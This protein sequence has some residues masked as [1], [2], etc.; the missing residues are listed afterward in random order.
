MVDAKTLGL[1]Q[2]V[3][4]GCLVGLVVL[5][6]FTCVRSKL[7]EVY[8]FRRYINR[9]QP[10]NNFNGARV[11]FPS[12][13]PESGLFGW[14]APTLGIEEEEIVS[15]IGLDAAMFLRFVKS[16]LLSFAIITIACCLV[17]W[18]AYGTASNKD[19]PKLA[20]GTNDPLF[21]EGLQILSLSNVPVQDARLWATLVMEYVVCAVFLFFLHKD[22]SQ[23]A[24]YRREYRTTENPAN[25][26]IVVYDIPSDMNTEDAVRERFELMVPDQVSEV[27]L[28]RKAKKGI[29]AEKILA[30]II[31]KKERAEFVRA[32]THEEP[33]T[34]PGCCGFCMCWK[35]KVEAFPFF[36]SEQERLEAEIGDEGLKAPNANSAIVVFKNKRAASLI[37]QANQ[38]SN[39]DQWTVHR[40]GEPEAVHWPAFHIPGYQAV[41]RSLA[42]IAFVFFMTFFWII[43][44]TAIMGLANLESLSKVP[45][46]GWASSITD[47]SPAVIGLIENA[48]PA[49]ILSV[50]F[51]LIPTFFRLAVS[52]TR[53]HSLHIIDSK[54]RNYFYIFTI[55]ASFVFV[56]FA[57]S[58][59]EELEAIRQDP[60][61][62]PNLLAAAIPR[63]GLFF[64]SFVL[65]KT[66]IPLFLLLLNPGRI[67]VRWIKLK[68][69]AKTERERRAAAEGGSIFAYFKFYGGC[70]MMSL[71]GLAYSTLAPVVSLAVLI[72]YCLS[73]VVF[74]HNIVFAT[75]RKWDG[76][77]WDY[78]GA[79]YSVIASLVLKQLTMIGVM[80]LF[81]SPAQ[82]TLAI[83]PAVITT[84]FGIWCHHRYSRVSLHGSLHD[85]YAEGS[86]V[87]EIPPRYQGLYRHPG[88]SVKP[89]KNLSGMVDPGDVYDEED[90]VG[91]EADAQA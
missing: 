60:G 5:L 51:A 3:G 82:T 90:E 25:Y 77:G 62:L 2:I 27:I 89:Y 52:Q 16:Q 7:P 85:Q 13:R 86:K 21:V 44:A 80:G 10:Y 24:V 49:I 56:V 58:I 8:Q 28:A 88:I 72:F 46:M 20:D 11:G 29:K 91:V 84:L 74:K 14:I 87:D 19:L 79:F 53:L 59:F 33:M 22:Y 23:Y 73:Y 63:N 81:Q 39:S 78:P 41:W 35:P 37:A 45:G 47:F 67:I 26:A 61:Q 57:G 31:S 36:T 55:F 71:I 68:F 18:P 15:R 83:F 42:V 34:R 54:T 9:Y 40:A 66:F 30:K 76:G 69:L 64:A 12:K 1:L 70:M 32:E 38:G 65:V 75:H 6:I 48:L 17:L 4:I 50:F 43:P